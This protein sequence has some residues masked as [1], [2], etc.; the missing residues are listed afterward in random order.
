[1]RFLA[2]QSAGSVAALTLGLAIPSG[3]MMVIG[4]I[5][6]A[7]IGRQGIGTWADWFADNPRT[8]VCESP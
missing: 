5:T 4:T 2:S 3:V 6:Y 7:L 1:M 8:F